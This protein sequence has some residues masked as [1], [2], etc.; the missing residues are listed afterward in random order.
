[1]RSHEQLLDYI[2]VIREETRISRFVRFVLRADHDV[3]CT[4]SRRL[5]AEE[6]IINAAL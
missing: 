4:A 6:M 3:H 2:A 1:L 5:K